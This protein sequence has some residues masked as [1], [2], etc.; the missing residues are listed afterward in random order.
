MDS[1]LDRAT[2]QIQSKKDGVRERRGE[3]KMTVSCCWNICSA[4]PQAMLWPSGSSASAS[5]HGR[6]VSCLKFGFDGIAEIAHNKV[7][8]QFGFQF[9]SQTLEDF[10]SFYDVILNGKVLIAAG[11]SAA[12]GQFSK[13][14]TY[15]IFYG[16]GFDLRAVLQPGGFPSSHSS[17][18]SNIVSPALICFYCFIY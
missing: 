14:F 15:A 17:V 9:W 2:L 12:V 8:F 7:R 13:P 6:V 16:K 5:T 11:V 1:G 4:T 3:R 10:F 18:S